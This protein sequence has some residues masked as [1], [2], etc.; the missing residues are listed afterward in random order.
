[1]T[2]IWKDIVGY[3][4]YEVSTLGRVRNKDTGKCFK[5]SPDKDGYLRVCLTFNKKETTHKIH[6]LVAIAFLPNFYAHLTVN[7][8]DR[9]KTNNKLWNLEWSDN[10]RQSQ[11]RDFVINA[12]NI[13]KNKNG[14]FQVY[15]NRN[16]IRYQKYFK[17]Y[18]DALAWREQVLAQLSANNV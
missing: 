15:I 11:N 16:N 9:N 17:K 12:K 3:D 2:E 1:M 10:F 13:C 7:H 14:Y 5:G 6:R 8:K 18:E 4:N